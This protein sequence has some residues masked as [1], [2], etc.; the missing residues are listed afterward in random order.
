M[1]KEKF[2]EEQLDYLNKLLD[3]RGLNVK[4]IGRQYLVNVVELVF[5]NNNLMLSFNTKVYPEVAKIYGTKDINVEKSVRNAILKSE[6]KKNNYTT[7]KMFVMD[8][9]QKLKL[10]SLNGLAELTN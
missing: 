10:F 1:N 3:E 9:V 4:W 5:F 2:N 7:T 6:Y 8:L